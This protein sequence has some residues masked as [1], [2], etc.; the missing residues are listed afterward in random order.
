MRSYLVGRK[1]DK[2]VVELSGLYQSEPPDR[3]TIL[4]AIVGRHGGSAR[5]YEVVYIDDEASMRRLQKG[6]EGSVQ[7][8][9]E[10]SP[11]VF[12]FG[13]EDAK[14]EL[15]ISASKDHVIANGIDTTALTFSAG[16][17][18]GNLRLA[19]NSPDG[20]FQLSLSLASGV[21]SVSFRTARSGTWTFGARRLR[22]T[23]E[24]RIAAPLTIEAVVTGF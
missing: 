14:P 3:A 1:S 7:Y 23:D 15:T 5:D 18:T 8:S 10:A 17:I 4:G 6:D 2:S 22:T 11:A 19:C 9:D 16:T 12:A 13:V 20:P 24:Y 21:G